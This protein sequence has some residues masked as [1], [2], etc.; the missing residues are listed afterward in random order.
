M[1]DFTEYEL[2]WPR[3]LFAVE[4]RALL[5]DPGSDRWIDRV[6]LLLVEAFT[7]STPLEDFNSIGLAGFGMTVP[8]GHSS[9]WQFAT[10]LLQAAP[11]LRE[12]SA[13]RPY[14]PARN[15]RQVTAEPRSRDQVR[16]DFAAL[17]SRMQHDGY[18]DRAF[19]EP[20]VDDRDP[21]KP[22]PAAEIARRLGLPGLWPLQPDSWDDDTFYA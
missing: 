21:V 14:W 7:D 10:Q 12:Q 19:P 22:D 18:L 16:H 15:S 9:Q 6:E 1:P 2:T 8:T 4:L 13:P 11:D 3:H 20:C 17:V 5:A